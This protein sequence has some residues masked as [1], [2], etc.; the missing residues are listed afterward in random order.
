MSLFAWI[1]LISYVSAT[2]EE[3]KALSSAELQS[4]EA[5]LVEQ[6]QLNDNHIDAMLLSAFDEVCSNFL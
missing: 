5:S 4:V 3:L 1:S 6:A 2:S